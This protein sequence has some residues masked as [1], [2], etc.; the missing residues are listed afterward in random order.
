MD[1][2]ASAL[3]NRGE[4]GTRAG[5]AP[6]PTLER[7]GETG[8]LRRKSRTTGSVVRRRTHACAGFAPGPMSGMTFGWG[9]APR[10]GPSR[11][12]FCFIGG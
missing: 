7:R 4:T 3:W 12:R 2:H 6:V 1:L 5:Q 8:A 10:I 11:E 9:L